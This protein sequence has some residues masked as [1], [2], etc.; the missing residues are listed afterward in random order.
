VHDALSVDP[1]LIAVSID[2][3]FM[4][5]ADVVLAL[6]EESR[7]LSAEIARTRMALRDTTGPVAGPFGSTR[8]TPARNDAP[9]PS[10]DEVRS[11][12]DALVSR[13]RDAGLPLAPGM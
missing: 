1:E 6:D 12:L 4:R 8:A 10:A 13:R 2:Y 9:E 3:G 7:R 5:A 11:R